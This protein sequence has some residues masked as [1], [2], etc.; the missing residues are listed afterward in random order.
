MLKIALAQLDF[1]LGDITGN[2]EKIIHAIH[3]AKAQSANMIIFSELAISG[4]PPEDLL[5]DEALYEQVDTALMR[6]KQESQ[7]CY[8]IV[9]HPAKIKE[10]RFNMASVFYNDKIIATY[11][12]HFLPNYGV[13]DEARYFQPSECAPCVFDM[14]GIKVGLI[15]CE[16]IWYET[17]CKK[18]IEQDAECVVVINASPYDK[19][20]FAMREQIL[21]RR[22]EENHVPIIYV[23]QVG[24]QDELIFDG[25][26]LALD[27]QGKLCALAKFCEEDLLF[28]ELEKSAKEKLKII[29]STLTPPM[30]YEAELYSALVLA[31]HDY[32]K[33]N[34]FKQVFLGLSGGIDS[35]LTLT[36]AVDALGAEHVTAL[37][38][39]S[40][41][42]ASMSNE[43]ALS[44]AQALHVKTETIT[45]EPAFNALLSMLAPAFGD[46][47][48][49]VTEKNIQARIRGLI[50]MAMANKFHG[51]VLTTSNKSETAVGYSTLYG[52][53]AGGF[54]LLKDVYKTDV[55][56]LAAYRNQRGPVIPLRTLTRAP[57][58]ELSAGETDQD[59]L[60]PY[61]VL[62]RLLQALIEENISAEKVI[63]LGFE[64]E[65]VKKVVRLLKNSEHKRRQAPIGPRITVRAF[66]KDWRFPVSKK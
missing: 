35:A 1:W 48:V 33:K 59:D 23:N 36:L 3:K 25:R 15:I 14:G 24:G 30:T 11:Q 47:A 61:D 53:M 27:A 46:A 2:T 62:D 34:G 40:R 29:S 4:Y 7:D 17:P 44:L 41:Y 16:D 20:K 56:R 13:F 22:I 6:I 26:S 64:R 51:M 50:A 9:G 45:I 5:F 32:V 37:I 52:D 66:G 43:D 10:T 39:P 31:L 21:M 8:V 58:A 12:K 57:S 55:Y 49:D 18:A 60:P 38:M 19:Q 28:V 42:T 63:Q 54:A 65:M